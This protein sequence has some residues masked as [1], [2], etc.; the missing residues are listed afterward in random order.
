MELQLSVWQPT[1]LAKITG[2]S[3]IIVVTVVNTAMAVITTTALATTTAVT[4]VIPMVTGVVAMEGTAVTA[5][6]IAPAIK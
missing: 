2:K 6:A 4:V 1:L 3:A 5:G